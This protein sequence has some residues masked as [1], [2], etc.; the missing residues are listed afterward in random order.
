MGRTPYEF[1]INWFLSLMKRVRRS[2]RV[3]Y[4]EVLARGV[5]LLWY[6][7][8]VPPE[9]HQRAWITTSQRVHG[10]TKTRYCGSRG[11]IRTRLAKDEH[12]YVLG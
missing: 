7:F 3:H 6:I 4:S 11:L 8:I 1:T 12:G 5:Y 2:R 9:D 10:G